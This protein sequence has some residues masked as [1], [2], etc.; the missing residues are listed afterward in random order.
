MKLNDIIK[1]S[2]KTWKNEKLMNYSDSDVELLFLG[3]ALGGEDGE[4]QN[5]VKKYFRYKY[6]SQSHASDV[7][8][9][10]AK[11]EV[12]DVLFYIGRIAEKL[13]M[14][15]E[16]EFE[17]KMEENVKRFGKAEIRA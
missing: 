12:T 6:Y 9:A 5:K 4:L 14:D 3:T 8:L 10:K 16:K 1:E 2:K 17:K 7:E 11:E 15:V 13:G